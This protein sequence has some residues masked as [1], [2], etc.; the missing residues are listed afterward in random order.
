M[1]RRGDIVRVQARNFSVAVCLGGGSYMGIRSKFN[2]LY[3]D[4]EYSGAAAFASVES[5]GEVIGAVPEGMPLDRNSD[6]LF[7]LLCTYQPHHREDIMGDRANIYV[8]D[9]L[10]QADTS[11]TQGIYLYT[12]WNGEDWPEQ[13]RAAL[14]HK[15]ARRRWNDPEY[16]LRILVDQLFSDIRDSELGGGIGTARTSGE[17]P[18][19]V[20]DTMAGYVGFAREGE[21]TN[22][23]NWQNLLSFEGFCALSLADYPKGLD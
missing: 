7:N 23:D 21:E 8:V 5:V 15:N 9:R 6:E 18:V 4:I 11:E 22:R 13:L 16:L 12:H 19:I 1:R 10:P 20:V 3:L 2:R 17:H 14:N